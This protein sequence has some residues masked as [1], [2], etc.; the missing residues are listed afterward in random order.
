MMAL[1]TGLLLVAFCVFA[2]LPGGA[3]HWGSFVVQFLKGA[4]PVFAGFIGIICLFIGAADIK[5]K[6]E[7]AK[8]ERLAQE[9]EQKASGKAL[10]E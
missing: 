2:L 1:L 6:R 4:T 9:T 5:D 8:E 7:A 3:L 10:P